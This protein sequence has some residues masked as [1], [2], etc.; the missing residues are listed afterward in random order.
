MSPTIQTRAKLLTPPGRGAVASIAVS[1]PDAIR[2][3]ESL[4]QPVQR[5]P[6]A[7]A[8]MDQIVFG[9]WLFSGE[10][11]V[12]ARR[13]DRIEIHCHG[14]LASARA[15]LDDLSRSGCEVVNWHAR[16]DSG[17]GDRARDEAAVALAQA[18]TLRTAAILLD[19]YQGAL[20]SEVDALRRLAAAGA[21]A[22]AAEERI[23]ALLAWE[24]LGTHL[25]RPFQV[26]LTGPPN[27]GK[28]SLIN[29]ILG[30]ERAI[31]HELP[32]TTR[33]VVS[34]RTA[35]DGWPVELADTAGI[36]AAADPLEAA[37]IARAKEQLTSADAVICVIDG[38]QP[39]TV[40]D[41]TA[42]GEDAFVAVNKSD[43]PAAFGWNSPTWISVSAKT[44]AGLPE[45][46]SALA[47]ILVPCSP[48]PGVA[49]PFTA[50][51]F[52]ALRSA[53]SLLE[54]GDLLAASD[55]LERLG[56]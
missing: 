15:I 11:V 6:F 43:L 30:Y 17:S 36:H 3:M 16:P 22:A 44:G 13:H 49:V 33:D 35:I 10:E 14:G 23:R 7:E 32:G 27:V 5:R 48:L 47:A 9:H 21:C 34:A 56:C 1:G 45:L 19:Q 29:A 54:R 28:S 20:Q 41:R 55:A 40:P 26:V 18:S 51:Q 46:L 8:A 42:I 50:G 39:L 2:L 52:E 25:T 31:V 24:R 37:G 12:L 53:L 38:S 4:F